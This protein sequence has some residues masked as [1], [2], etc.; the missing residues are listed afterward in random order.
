MDR[1]ANGASDTGNK[2]SRGDEPGDLTVSVQMEPTL[3]SQSQ[4]VALASG[5][6][7]PRCGLH[8]AVRLLS[9]VLLAEIGRL[10][11]VCG[12]RHVGFSMSRTMGSVTRSKTVQ[13]NVFVAISPTLGVV[14]H[15]CV[16]CEDGTTLKGSIGPDRFLA[17]RHA[18]AHDVVS[19][20][21]GRGQPVVSEVAVAP[22]W[23]MLQAACNYGWIVMSATSYFS[24]VR[25]VGGE[26]V[27]KPCEILSGVYEFQPRA[28]VFASQSG[29]IYAL[30][31]KKVMGEEESMECKILILDL[32][33]TLAKK[34]LTVLQ[35]FSSLDSY[36]ECFIVGSV[37]FSINNSDHF[38]QNAATGETQKL[39]SSEKLTIHRAGEDTNKPSLSFPSYGPLDSSPQTGRTG[40]IIVPA[41]VA[42]KYL[43]PPSLSPMLPQSKSLALV[44]VPSGTTIALMVLSCSV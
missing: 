15:N 43:P 30:G 17:E 37:C 34:A 11:V 35:E 26:M 6:L 12:A 8:S 41:A 29:D 14:T 32:A 10:W 28:G 5:C 24:I 19:I 33:Q 7:I 44:D 4:F 38:I 18:G 22:W 9:P 40:I 16:E 23:S 3:T 39:P 21:D 27:G 31:V 13:L 25:V 42:P 20:V 2:E 36:G 1:N